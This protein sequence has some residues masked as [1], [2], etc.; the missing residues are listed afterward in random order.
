MS[1][2]VH[3]QWPA[4]YKYSPVY[5]SIYSLSEHL[6]LPSVSH[7]HQNS[8]GMGN[9]RNIKWSYPLL[10][11][12]STTARRRP[13]SESGITVEFGVSPGDWATLFKIA[14]LTPTRSKELE[15]ISHW[16]SDRNRQCYPTYG[17]NTKERWTSVHGTSET[18]RRENSQ[19]DLRRKRT[20]MLQKLYWRTH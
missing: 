17:Q 3:I 19:N 1:G 12:S 6:K 10:T 18:L 16:P 5:V 13:L 4:N 7:Y 2:H 20:V 15:N 9:R 14:L 8:S 11:C